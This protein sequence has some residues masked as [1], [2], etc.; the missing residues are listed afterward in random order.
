VAT[1]ATALATEKPLAF[2]NITVDMG[3][4]GVSAQH[5]NVGRGKRHAFHAEVPGWRHLG[6]GETKQNDLSQFFIG[7]GTPQFW[8]GQA[9]PL[10]AAP[11]R[12]VTAGAVGVEDAFGSREVNSRRTRGCGIRLGQKQQQRQKRQHRLAL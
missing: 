3:R 1:C 5:S 12:T 4:R 2:D 9:G 10:T 8:D 6:A 7:P 11:L